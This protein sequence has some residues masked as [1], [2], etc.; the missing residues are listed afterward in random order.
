MTQLSAKEGLGDELVFRIG[1][2]RNHGPGEPMGTP[3][4][5]LG[6]AK[7]KDSTMRHDVSADGSRGLC[8]PCRTDPGYAIASVEFGGHTHLVKYTAETAEEAGR[9]LARLVVAAS[10]GGAEIDVII[11]GDK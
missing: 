8:S 6:L 10:L 4:G 7:G 3:V 9:I 2:C 11:E 1:V 5:D